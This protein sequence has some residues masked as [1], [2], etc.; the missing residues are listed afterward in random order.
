M[1]SLH[2]KANDVISFSGSA[3]DAQD[4]SLPASALSWTLDLLHCPSSCHTHELN[5]WTGYASGFFAAPD[6]EYPSHLILTLTATDSGGLSASTSVQLDPKTVNL[7]LQSVPAGLQLV[8]NDQSASTPFS[9]TVIVGSTNVFTA[10]AF[11][12]LAGKGY[13][14]QSWSDAGAASHTIY[15]PAAPATWTATYKPSSFTVTPIADA[16]VKST[17]PG[18]N[19]GKATSLRALTSET[20]SYLKFSI[21]GLAAPAKDVRLRLWV[22]NPSS[23]GVDVYRASTNS[24]SETGVTWLHKPGLGVYLRSATNAVAGTWLTIDL[25]TAITANGTYTLALRGRSSDAAWFASRET[26][27]DPQLV[28][29]R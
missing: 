22:T 13:V 16:F 11:Q 20:R 19:Y 4:G 27:H 8:F 17:T 23:P 25:G 29:Y 10:P 12:T 7:T 18:T 2:W 28:V 21:S 6:H 26:S 5:T 15:A 24:W 9:R 3:T 1:A 14:F